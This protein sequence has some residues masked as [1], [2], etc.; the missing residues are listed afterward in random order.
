MTPIVEAPECFVC[1]DSEP[2]PRRSACKCTDRYVHDAC[3]VKML[4]TTRYA[5]CP[6]CA[7]PYTNVASRV[8]VVGVDLCSRGGMVLGAAVAA[9][10]L[11]TTAINTWLVYCCGQRN[12]SSNEDFVV[13]FAA[14]LMT[15]VGFASAAFV[16]RE[17]LVAGPRH[18]LRSMQVRK[19]KVCV[20][21]T[22]VAFGPL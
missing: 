4:E 11:V 15:S 6:V 1:T 7:A 22:E 17:C 16:G 13:C 14:I 8:T 20:H 9:M 18:L 10:V 2:P 21:P 19:R 12:L 3:L 5:R